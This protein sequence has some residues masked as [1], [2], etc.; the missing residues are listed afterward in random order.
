MPASM[1]PMWFRPISATVFGFR[2]RALSTAPP[3]SIARGKVM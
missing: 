1:P 2:M 3:C